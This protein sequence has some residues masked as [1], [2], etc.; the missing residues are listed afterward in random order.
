MEQ[1]P[2]HA[3]DEGTL[4]PEECGGKDRKQQRVVRQPEPETIESEKWKVKSGK[5]IG[6]GGA[7]EVEGEGESEPAEDG[8]HGIGHAVVALADEVTEQHAGAVARQSAPRAGHIANLRHQQH[9]DKHQHTTADG[10]HDGAPVGLRRQLVPEGEV[11]IDAHE[12]LGHHDDGDSPQALPVVAP[13]DVAE[14]VH[15]A[16]HH[17][18]GQQG[19]HDEI[20]HHEGLTLFRLLTFSSGK[21]KRLVGIA[22]GLGNHS[23]NH[24]NLHAGAVDAQLLTHIGT[25]IEEG[26]EYLVQHL[27]EDAHNAEDE[28]WPGVLEHALQKW[29]VESG[30]FKVFEFAPEAEGDEGGAE[31]VDIEDIADIV[32]L[33]VPLHEGQVLQFGCH[34]ED[35]EVEGDVEDDEGELQCGEFPRLVLVTQSG[36]EQRLEGIQR[37]DDG[38]HR[39]ILGV[40]PVAHSI[41]DGAQQSEN[42]KNEKET[43]RAHRAQSGGENIL[44]IL[45]FLIREIEEGGL[46]AE[47]ENHQQQGSIGVDVGDDAIATRGSGD[48][49]GVEGNEQVVE[50]P[51]NDAAQ[52]I[53]DRVGEKLFQ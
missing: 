32:L 5:C 23:H 25:G 44:A 18:E 4:A 3:A 12:Y 28:Q 52:A 9:I 43:H 33:I 50:E 36:K 19:E 22:E 51:A 26:E 48:M 15:I 11:E 39:N 17:H 41:G 24:G 2:H 35:E 38:H 45:A 21:D 6:R 31:E 34:E 13:D 42:T 37:N 16:H 40:S 10:A 7:E 47:G 49:V 20:L 53:D 8:R 29:K 14:H 1:L 46:H 30:K 27:V